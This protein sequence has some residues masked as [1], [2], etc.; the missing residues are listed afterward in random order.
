M[1]LDL[2]VSVSFEV[3]LGL[4]IHLHVLLQ[5]RT[6]F[7]SRVFVFHYCLGDAHVRPVILGLHGGFHDRR[8]FIHC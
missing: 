1:L 6:S 8:P 7:S 2:E 3:H 5:P 4:V